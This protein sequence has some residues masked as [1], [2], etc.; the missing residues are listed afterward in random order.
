MEKG[1]FSPF[2]PCDEAKF[3]FPPLILDKFVGMLGF[4]DDSAP[5]AATVRLEIF[6][7]PF[8]QL[9]REC[10]VSEWSAQSFLSAPQAI[11]LIDSTHENLVLGMASNG[12]LVSCLLYTS[13][14]PRDKR[15]SRMPSSA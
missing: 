9:L 2:G 3:L 5:I 13:P 8:S 15:Q 1:C 11:F 6:E 4:L 7:I 12:E 14:S 10:S